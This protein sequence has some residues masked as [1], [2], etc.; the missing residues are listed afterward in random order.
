MTS[1][2]MFTEKIYSRW[3]KENQ[4]AKYKHLKEILPEIKGN[5]LDIGVGPG[6][7]EEFLGI[8]AIGIDVDRES[9][10][11]VIASGDFLP[12]RDKTFDFVVC[13]DT[14]HLLNGKDVSRVM[15]GN[16]ILLVSHFVN[17]GNEE[18]VKKTLLNMFPEFKLSEGR[19]VGNKEKDLVLVLKK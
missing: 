15:R 3:M 18:K 16:G 1:D 19:I 11:R 6:W 13:L 9:A 7:F 10:A 2:N 14:I 5:V 8:K 4:L 17:K 12:F